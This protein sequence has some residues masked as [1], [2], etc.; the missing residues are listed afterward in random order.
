MGMDGYGKIAEQ[1]N[2]AERRRLRGTERCRV[3]PANSGRQEELWK[4]CS[5][6]GSLRRGIGPPGLQKPRRVFFPKHRGDIVPAGLAN[7]GHV[8]QFF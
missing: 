1:K 7:P 2:P 3:C 5:F 8:K 4:Q 6:R